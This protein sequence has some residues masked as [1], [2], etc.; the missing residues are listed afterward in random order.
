LFDLL[1]LFVKRITQKLLRVIFTK[2]GVKVARGTLKNPFEFPGH[3]LDHTALG[4][5]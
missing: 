5:E 2:S 1:C 4:L 3:N